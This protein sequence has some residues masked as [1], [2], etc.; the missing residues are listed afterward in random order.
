[1]ETEQKPK[2]KQLRP[3]LLFHIDIDEEY[4]IES[5]TSIDNDQVEELVKKCGIEKTNLFFTVIQESDS[6]KIHIMLPT[7]EF[8]T[9][10]APLGI[11]TKKDHKLCGFL[12]ISEY[13]KSGSLDLKFWIDEEYQSLPIAKNALMKMINYLMNL[14]YVSRISIPFV[15]DDEQ[16]IKVCEESGIV[17]EMINREACW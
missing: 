14:G 8:C 9:V 15:S 11:F 16:L 7:Y 1:M 12:R 6:F 4:R 3:I 17:K 10:D 13:K 5:L 2:E